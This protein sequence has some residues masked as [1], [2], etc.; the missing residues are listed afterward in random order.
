MIY[1]TTQF[2]EIDTALRR[3][4]HISRG[5]I[6]TYEFITQNFDDFESFYAAYGAR[7][8]QHPDGFFFLLAKGSMMPTR[9]LPRSGMHLGMFIA[10]KRR[11]PDVTR[12][13]GRMSIAGLIHDLETSVPAE[14]L[15]QV[16][17]PKQKASLEG[18]RI[19]SEVMRAFKLLAELDFIE[20]NGDQLI[21]HEAIN[22]F[23]ELA[24]NSNTP[25]ETAKLG[26]EIQRGV[27]FDIADDMTGED[28][29]DSTD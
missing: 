11:D 21:V 5:D 2:A 7:L 26:L 29:N 14:T 25:S 23:A 17:A 22:R 16:Y 3:G 18:E 4:R 19:H 24:K 9:I 28:S 20:I 1:T 6:G 8:I 13:D 10:F 15:A 27:V 12:S